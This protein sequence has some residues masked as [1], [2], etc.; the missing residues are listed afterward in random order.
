VAEGAAAAASAVG[1]GGAGGPPFIKRGSERR[2]AARSN[3]VYLGNLYFSVTEQDIK[4][5]FERF[6]K[7]EKV[8]LVYDRQGLSR[9]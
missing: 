5:A 9:G 8:N 1:L 3:A 4:S 7:V 6:G 2:T